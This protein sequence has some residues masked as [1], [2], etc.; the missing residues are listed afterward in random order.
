MSHAPTS[1]DAFD[2]LVADILS[3]A[4]DEIGKREQRARYALLADT[5]R[6][7]SASP[8]QC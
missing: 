7:S 1:S 8:R 3:C 4:L 5:P 2:E 6:V